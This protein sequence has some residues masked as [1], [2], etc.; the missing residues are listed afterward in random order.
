MLLSVRSAVRPR[1]AF[2]VFSIL[3]FLLVSLPSGF[4]QKAH[5]EDSNL[6][7]YDVQTETKTNGVIDEINQLPVGA[8]K[9]FTELIIKSGDDKFHIYVCPK[10]FQDEIGVSF[11]KGDQVAV[12][13]S[14]VK[15][16]ASDVILARELVKGTDTL[17]FRD[18]KGNPVWNWPTAK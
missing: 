13:G 16:D 3:L 4:A 6:P 15:Q 2:R 12:T 8:R 10:R 17:T 14:R 18:N 5:H 1:T 7:K 9:D 11:S